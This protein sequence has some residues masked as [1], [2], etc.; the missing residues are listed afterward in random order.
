M[1]LLLS[2]NKEHR[3]K[4]KEDANDTD[5]KTWHDTLIDDFNLPL[6][7]SSGQTDKKHIKPY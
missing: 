4:W 1:A 2:R 7:Y 5:A 3:K 6:P